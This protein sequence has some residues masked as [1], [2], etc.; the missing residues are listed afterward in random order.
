M[1]R[2]PEARKP[3]CSVGTNQ[4]GAGFRVALSKAR[5]WCCAVWLCSLAGAIVSAQAP[6]SAYR[7][8]G[9]PDLRENGVNLVQGTAMFNPVGVAL[10]GRDGPLHLYVADTRNHRILTWQDARASQMG[11]PP[12][13]IL[14]Q[15]G[16]QSSSVRGIGPKG[17]MF[18]AGLAVDPAS[19][20][21]YVADSGD[22]R[23]LRFPN[24]FTNP[25]RTD[26][27]AVY[28]QPDFATWVP[29]SGGI[30]PSSLSAPQ[31]VAFDTVGNLWIADTGNHR[32]L[33]INASALRGP[34]PQADVVIGQPDFF[35]GNANRGSDIGAQ[36]FDT[37][38]GLAFDQQNNLYVSDT[39]NGRVLKFAEPSETT[40]NAT[41]V[42]GQPNFNARNITPQPSASS[43]TG[44]AG[45]AVS[46]TGMLY[47]AL[48]GYNRVLLFA[49]D[50]PSGA[51]AIDVLGQPGFTTG[52]INFSSFPYASANSLA[53]VSDVKLDQ[54]GN[55]FLADSGNN[56]V[57][58]FAR[59]N[60][61][62]FRV[63]GQPDFKANGVNQI[64]SRGLNSPYQMV[65]DY[66]QAPF[67]IYVSDM[68]NHRILGW[69]D[70]VHFQTG[71]PADLVIWATGYDDRL[72]QRRYGRL[73]FR[74]GH[75]SIV[76]KGC[77]D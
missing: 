75:F 64:K 31:A 67:P 34:N 56:R 45:L 23:V 1:D 16:P 70:A 40:T 13:M 66:S 5:C 37:P 68:A 26:P 7:T 57:I 30:S 24:P 18:P 77:S 11:A 33:R 42:F 2:P 47:V 36:G 29:D 3:G 53:G 65:I 55:V 60:K 74:F 69:K 71:D 41:T 19:G 73:A 21:L 44:P 59:N 6:A 20:D 35:S 39:N 12:N 51:A 54:D 76:A 52:Q 4:M 14:G 9:Q 10:D 32:V 62:G 28:G 25:S 27:D 61:S 43:L 50:A 17:L 38:S 8:L 63:W 46:N 58:V 15:P 22:S 72:C 49:V 48:P